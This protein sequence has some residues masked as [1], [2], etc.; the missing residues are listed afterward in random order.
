MR[1]GP[2]PTA[3][4]SSR[5][6]AS[7]RCG[8]SSRCGRRR[9]RA[10]S[11]RRTQRLARE[12]GLYYPPDPVR[13]SSRSSRKRGHQRRRPHAFKYGVTGAWVTGLEVAIAPGEPSPSAVGCARTSPAT[14]SALLIGSEGTLG[15]VTA[16]RPKLIP[17]PQA[18]RPVVAFYGGTAAGTAA[19]M[20][21]MASGT[22]PAAIEF[23]DGAAFAI[24][25]RAPSRSPSSARP[26]RLRGDRRGGRKRG[27]GRDRPGAAAGSPFRRARTRC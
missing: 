9:S 8:R 4:S 3:A 7:G 16:V 1:A 20:H 27:R 2:S 23:L 14:T 21:A 10:G 6:P 17:P 22:L 5:S 15:I 25:G 11:R 18:R 24:S 19:V 12:N 26:P 13:P